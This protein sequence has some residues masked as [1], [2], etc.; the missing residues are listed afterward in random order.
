M[1]TVTLKG[2]PVKISGNPPKIGS[3]APSF[4]LTKSDL[5]NAKLADFA[6]ETIVL[7]IF[8]SIDTPVCSASV[9][10]F[11]AEAGNRNSVVVLCISMDLPFAHARFCEVEGLKNVTPLSA[12]RSPAFGKDYG[13]TITS[14]PLAG[15]LARTVIILDP[16]GK[17][18]YTE[19]VPEITQEPDYDA[20][21]KA[22]P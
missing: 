22:L 7:N 4:E 2:S 6:G 17:V 20:A 11:N 8:P 12:F 14:G 10:R 15:L 18:I 19:L 16:K 9:R 5:S 3:V 21:L 13:L 1:T